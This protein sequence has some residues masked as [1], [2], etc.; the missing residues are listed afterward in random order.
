[1]GRLT[2]LKRAALTSCHRYLEQ[3]LSLSQKLLGEAGLKV[4][5]SA[6]VVAERYS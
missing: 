4:G 5:D 2:Q 6:S 3:A 1:M